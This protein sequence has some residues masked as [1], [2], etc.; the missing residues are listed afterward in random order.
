VTAP[1]DCTSRDRVALICFDYEGQW[2]MPF[3]APYD[4]KLS[5]H[6][7][8]ELLARHEAE[9]IFFVVGALAAEHPELVR[10]ISA[11]GHEIALHGWR[12]E[13]LRHLTPGQLARVRVGLEESA[14]VIE[15]VTGARPVGFRA[16]YLLG[17]AFF[18]SA[19]YD[20]LAGQGYRWTSNREI[21]HVVQLFRPDR[22]GSERPWQYIRSHPQLLEGTAARALLVA[23]NAGIYGPSRAHDPMPSAVRWLLEGCRPFYRGALLEI[24]LY[25]PLDCDLVGLPEPSSCTPQR[26]LAY[27]RFA[28]EWYLSRPGPVTMVTFHDWIIA[29]ANRLQLLDDVLTFGRDTHIHPVTVT[30]S[31]ARISSLAGGA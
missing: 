5:T 12:H 14:A 31:W 25:S 2:G 7:I 15:S 16:P 20:L 24:P 9:A 13:H 29:G 11:G 28:L 30:N 27:A 23:L 17:P 6:R 4:L 22:I 8:L 10:A 21:R 3:V 18:D 19:L 26:L 1:G